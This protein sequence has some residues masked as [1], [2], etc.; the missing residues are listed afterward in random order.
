M[1]GGFDECLGLQKTFSFSCCHLKGIRSLLSSEE[2]GLQ[3]LELQKQDLESHPGDR[4]S[5]HLC[6]KGWAKTFPKGS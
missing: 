3:N 5:G 6:E 4:S 1:W 2:L